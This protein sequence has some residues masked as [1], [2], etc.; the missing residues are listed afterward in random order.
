MLDPR[1]RARL[2]ETGATVSEQ[3]SLSEFTTLRLGGPARYLVECTSTASLIEVV[4]LLDEQ[5]VP[6]LLL[7][8]GSNLVI[9][10]DGFDGVV[11]RVA[12]TGVDL[13][14]DHVRVDAG[15][16]W[17]AVVAATVDAGLGGLECLSGIPGS[18]GATPVQNVGAYGVEVGSILRRVRLLDRATGQDSWVGP[19]ALGLGYRTSILKHTDAAVVLEV[20]LDVRSDGSSAPLAYRE[21]A[22][23]LGAEEG[24]RRPADQVREH[25]LALRRSK[26]MVLDADDHDTWSAG[27]F[28]TNPVVP[29]DRL[30]QVLAVIAEKVGEDVRI[31]QFPAD[32]G[33]KLS[34]GWL[35]ERAGFAKGF[36]AADAPARLST[37]HTL[38]LTNRGAASAADLVALA[39]TVRD[40]VE[41]AFGVR[42]HPEPVTV[43][44]AI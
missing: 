14:D 39:R 25:V 41:D 8:G 36:P 12:T 7:A 11:V 20:E 37:K 16:E 31:P 9:G 13:R 32:G 42:L 40:G 21:L 44:C 17:D 10:D 27:S 15:A 4:R 34:A 33:T 3:V 28:F 2:V 18:T 5:R 30:P 23:A 29:D 6:L 26:G 22:V 43:N 38:A 35:I 19:E 1:T 24:E